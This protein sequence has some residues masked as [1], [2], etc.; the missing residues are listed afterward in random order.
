MYEILVSK[1]HGG[2]LR[3]PA[4]RRLWLA[5]LISTFGDALTSFSLILLIN[6]RTGSAAAIATLAVFVALPDL[7]FGM[8]AGVLVDRHDRRRIMLASD[9]LRALLVLGLV[10]LQAAS[11]LWPLYAL[12]F[13]QAG[14][15]AFFAP[16]RGALVQR[17][18]AEPERMS[19][20]AM[21]E[22]A[23]TLAEISGTAVAGLLVGL[24]GAFGL[25]FAI[26]AATFA[27]SFGL[28]LGV[29]ASSRDDIS[30]VTSGV[31][32][33]FI[34]GLQTIRRNP[35]IAALLAVMAAMFLG[36]AAVQVL[37]VP[38]AIDVL[39]IPPQWTGF[40]SAGMVAGM[41][42]GSGGIA[43]FGGRLRADRLIAGGLFLFALVILGL[44]LITNAW[45]LLLVLCGFG[46]A[47]VIL[48]VSFATLVQNRIANELMG[49]VG[50]MFG[51]IAAAA[52]LTSMAAAGV[53]ADTLGVQSV[54]R[55]AAALMAIAGVLAVLLIVERKQPG[56]L[57]RIEQRP[58]PRSG[59]QSRRQQL[60]R[61]LPGPPR[62]FRSANPGRWWRGREQRCR[63]PRGANTSQ[64]PR[65][66]G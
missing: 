10:V 50:G 55:I 40:F 47:Q 37:M 4:F 19:A 53:L 1:L 23:V 63:A 52:S 66:R 56:S 5:Q 3:Q 65:L 60:G 13:V 17:V 35:E 16:A 12:A 44:G 42:L 41:L 8:L 36:G 46:A 39:R 28:V 43:S 18:V 54:L 20:N 14:V 38:L 6:Q 58:P 32:A 27:I 64:R 30:A 59:H 61:T 31:W 51:T 48:Q 57:P 2:P 15:G 62:R 11:S 24:T 7:A 9:L 49:R 45:L 25:A 33:S 22:S 21:S 34:D 29:R 26:D